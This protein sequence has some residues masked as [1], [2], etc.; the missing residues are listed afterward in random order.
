MVNEYLGSRRTAEVRNTSSRSFL[1]SIGYFAFVSKFRNQT[2]AI[3]KVTARP[4]ESKV[5]QEVVL[6]EERIDSVP[7]LVGVGNLPNLAKIR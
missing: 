4:L 7:K 2:H 6:V 3:V 1:L 5:L